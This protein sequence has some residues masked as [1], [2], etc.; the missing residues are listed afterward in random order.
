[1]NIRAVGL[2]LLAAGLVMLPTMA[3][4]QG[5]TEPPTP[6]GTAQSD[7]IDA[8]ITILNVFLILASLVAVVFLILGG[9][10]YIT[11]QGSEDAA[12]QAKSTILYAVIGLI[13]IGL[14]A[15]L[16]RFV[17]QAIQSA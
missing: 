7:L 1:M 8:V 13:V 15:A 17:V 16:V 4:A 5:L 9:V 12:D 14:A 6:Q 2:S 10:R 3:L 11:S